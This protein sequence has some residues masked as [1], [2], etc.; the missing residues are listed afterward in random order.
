LSLPDIAEV[1]SLGD[2]DDHGQTAAS[3]PRGNA[4]AEAPMIISMNATVCGY[5]N[6]GEQGAVHDHWQRQEKE[7]SKTMENGY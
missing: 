7:D 4:A 2:G 3:F 1:V 5:K 6:H